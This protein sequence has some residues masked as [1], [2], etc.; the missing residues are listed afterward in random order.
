M[1]KKVLVKLIIAIGIVVMG[2][3]LT[4][5][6]LVDDKKVDSLM[7]DNDEEKVITVAAVNSG[8]PYL[9]RSSTG[10]E[11]GYNADVLSLLSKN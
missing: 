10:E 7:D 4:M 1:T 8:A 5:G 2:F 11:T 3:F 9:Y 6:Y